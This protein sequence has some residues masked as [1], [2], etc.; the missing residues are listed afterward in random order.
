MKGSQG[1]GK[2][3]SGDS[4]HLI[5]STFRNNVGALINNVYVRCVFIFTILNPSL[6]SL[7]V[8]GNRT[9]AK[10]ILELD[11]TFA[12]DVLGRWDRYTEQAVPDCKR[13]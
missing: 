7:V 8:E 13:S 9:G 11:P 4:A 3:Q 2:K 1:F 5:V 10:K 6:V 12:S